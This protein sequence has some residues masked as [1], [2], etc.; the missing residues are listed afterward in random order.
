MPTDA[1][2][3]YGFIKKGIEAEDVFTVAEFTDKPA[4]KRL[5]YSIDYALMETSNNVVVVPLD[6]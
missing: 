6:A 3:G 4:K 5:S 2:T 1:N